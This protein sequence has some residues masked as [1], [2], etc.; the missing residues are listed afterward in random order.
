MAQKQITAPL[1]SDYAPYH[2]M[3]P[4]MD[5]FNDSMNSVLL[6]H[7]AAYGDVGGQAYDRGREFAMRCRR[8]AS[9]PQLS[10]EQVDTLEGVITALDECQINAGEDR[11]AIEGAIAEARRA[12]EVGERAMAAIARALNDNEVSA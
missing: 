6:D 7:S 2:T 11:T 9:R 3:S 8:W 5:G 4:F 10:A 12:D 1:A